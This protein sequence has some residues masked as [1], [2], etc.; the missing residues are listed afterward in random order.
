M[1][2]HQQRMPA[3]M[4]RNNPT[5]RNPMQ[6]LPGALLYSRQLPIPHR[7][8]LPVT[9]KSCRRLGWYQPE[10]FV[11][12]SLILGQ[13]KSRCLCRNMNIV[14]EFSVRLRRKHLYFKLYLPRN[15]RIYQVNVPEKAVNTDFTST[16]RTNHNSEPLC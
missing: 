16:H 7:R 12:A 3:S 2:S 15:Y 9:S 6:F 5:T 4:N 11:F 8:L 14:P 10:V 1:I 13:K